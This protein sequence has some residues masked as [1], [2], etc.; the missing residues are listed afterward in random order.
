MNSLSATVLSSVK[1]HRGKRNIALLTRFLVILIANVLLYSLLFQVFMRME[2]RSEY[3]WITGL[4]WTIA[5]MT[6]TGFG[7]VVFHSVMGH[8]FSVLVMVTGAIYLIVLLPFT[9]IQFFLAPWM[10]AQAAARTPRQVPADTSGHV[11]LTDLD[12]VS[13]AMIRKLEQFGPRYVLIVPN[14]EEVQRLSDLGFRVMLGE[15]DDPETYVRARADRAAMVVAT[16]SDAENTNVVFTVR[17]VAERTPVIATAM[18]SASISILELAGASAVMQLGAVM[19][20]SLARCTIGGDAITHVV[21]QFDELLIAEANAARTPLVGRTLAENRI[22]DLG[23]TVLGVWTRGVFHH[24]TPET[25]VEANTILVLV[26]SAAQLQN[27]DEHFAIYNVTGE[28]T[29]ILGGGRIGRAAAEALEERHITWRVVEQDPLK[30]FDAQRTIVGNAADP[31]VLE[32]A[33]ID[34]APAV[35]VTTHDDNVNLYLTIICRRLR[36]N[37]QIISRSTLERNV[38]TLHRAGADFVISY[39][40]TGAEAI[41][42]HLKRRRVVTLAEGLDIFRTNVPEPLDGKTLAECGVREQT[43]C[44]IVAV[45]AAGS[46]RINPPASTVLQRGEDIVVVG[47]SDAVTR[48]SERYGQS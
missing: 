14:L 10:E 20:R 44:S 16:R 3:D 40:S 5:A 35:L 6:S 9:F 41:F 15:L 12:P 46:M 24:A 42:N 38:A 4:Y 28:P 45:G 8:A 26:G 19:G 29:L 13:Q 23:V 27:Y 21:G 47:D 7:D 17:S 34:K 30:V 32:R 31:A 37:M 36:P 25:M 11:I 33:G 48:F 18:D 39:A 2:G 22:S 43:G 1:K